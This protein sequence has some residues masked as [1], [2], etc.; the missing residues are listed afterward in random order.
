ML[1]P[2]RGGMAVSAKVNGPAIQEH[3]TLAADFVVA[4]E[5]IPEQPF[6]GAGSTAC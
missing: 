2:L 3:I 1:L 6:A 5:A 4:Q